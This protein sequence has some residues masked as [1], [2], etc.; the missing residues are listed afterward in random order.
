MSFSQKNCS[1]EMNRLEKSRQNMKKLLLLLGVFP[2]LL[3]GQTVTGLYD[4][5]NQLVGGLPHGNWFVISMKVDNDTILV[6]K[7]VY[8]MGHTLSDT[9]YNFKTGKLIQTISYKEGLEDGVSKE[10][11][12][13][14]RLR[15]EVPYRQGVAD[16]VVRSYSASGELLTQL[17]Y[18]KGV[19]EQ[20]YP[21]RYLSDKIEHDT[22]YVGFNQPI[23]KYYA[24]YDT[25][26][27]STYCSF[28]S[29]VQYYK[30]NTLYKENVYNHRRMLEMSTLYTNGV[31]DTVY[32]FYTKK[33]Y[34]G[35]QCIRYYQAGKLTNTVYYDTKGRIF[36]NQKR[37]ER[38][39]LGR[40]T[41][42]FIRKW[43]RKQ[44]GDVKRDNS[45]PRT[46]N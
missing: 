21:D 2:T 7:T 24:K 39:A 8:E 42:S 4:A 5:H 41:Y 31:K 23:W 14:G 1:Q 36:K 29:L 34:N 16:G 9:S 30:N 19:E 46:V 40:S 17:F 45:T 35:L 3:F 12:P 33:H 43:K 32:D 11:W 22:S 26:I 20:N 18:V 38:K 13:D 44:A 10:Y 28:D 6:K 27:D 25:L 37:G 15:G